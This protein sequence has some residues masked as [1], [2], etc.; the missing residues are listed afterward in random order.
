[1]DT[2]DLSEFPLLELP[3]DASAAPDEARRADWNAILFYGLIVLLLI[4]LWAFPYFPSQDGPAHGYVAVV[5]HDYDRPDRPRFREFFERNDR[6]V[7][8]WI[9]PHLL[10][11]LAGMFPVEIGEKILWSAYLI[12]LPLSARYAL[13]AIR[14]RAA[15]L[16]ISVIPFVPNI[17]Y[18]FGFLDFCLSM[19]FFFFTVGYWLKN[20]RCL[21]LRQVIGLA[22]LLLVGYF[23]HLVPTAMAGLFVT[24]L[25]LT[26]GGGGIK[27]RLRRLVPVIAAGTPVTLLA[28]CFLFSQRSSLPIQPWLYPSRLSRLKDLIRFQEAFD[29]RETV[30]V[31]MS[32][33]LFAGASGWLLW[34]RH[35]RRFIVG[36]DAFL[37]IAALCGALFL[38]APDS[39]G[40]GIML[41]V[42]LAMFPFLALLLWWGAQ[43]IGSEAFRRL[44]LAC[45]IV[46]TTV[47]LLLIASMSMSYAQMTPY[48]KD[49]EAVT[50]RID[51]NSTLLVRSVG[52]LNERLKIHGPD[53]FCHSGYRQAAE[54]GIAIVNCM[55]AATNY[56]PIRFRPGLIAEDHS[57]NELGAY[58]ARTGK[59]ID[60]VLLVTG[61]V[62]LD[63]PSTRLLFEQIGEGYDL[64]LSSPQ[65]GCVKL[66]RRKNWNRPIGPTTGAVPAQRARDQ[67]E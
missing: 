19:P 54:R 41:V 20:R 49:I 27:A 43:P 4:P 12:L 61:G 1:M 36:L 5:A 63:T 8:N 35:N 66:Y 31:L 55:P 21:G 53:V 16:A 23:C 29:R 28:I 57:Q 37:L 67:T 40:G 3:E 39:G 7:P 50:Q 34:R 15:A 44:R 47:A 62:I 38:T 24:L 33:A 52:L 18:H 14:P 58:T 25:A 65:T 9:G 32:L 11:V 51:P 13:G 6:F 48:I 26:M 30:L 10:A 64:I 42:R 60:Y 59:Q 22:A 2:S 56:H 17:Y 46:S 45:T